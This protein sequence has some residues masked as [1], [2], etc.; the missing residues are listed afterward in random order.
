MVPNVCYNLKLTILWRDWETFQRK[1]IFGINKLRGTTIT[2]RGLRWWRKV[3]S[4]RNLKFTVLGILYIHSNWN[5]EFI[6]FGW[7]ILH[8]YWTI[9]EFVSTSKYCVSTILLLFNKG[10]ISVIFF[11]RISVNRLLPRV[12]QLN[13]NEFL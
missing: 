8:I 9:L 1:P 5:N 13:S 4:F 2:L 10:L 3:L 6:Q 7:I 12:K 11:L